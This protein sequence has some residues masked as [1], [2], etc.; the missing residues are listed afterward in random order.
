MADGSIKID[1]KIDSSSLPKQLRSMETEVKKST[2]AMGESF[3]K[4]RDVMQ[5]PVA[6]AKMVKD[7]L[8]AIGKAIIGPAA[9]IEDFVAA[10]TPLTGSV[11]DA[12]IM[13]SALNK[14]AATTP[15]ELT[16]IASVGKQLLPV[17]GNDVKKVTETFRML[18]DTAGGNAEKLD[19]IARGYVK[20]MNTGKVSME[21]LNMIS[22]AGVPIQSQLAKSMGITVEEM[23]KLSS[24]GNISASE[25]TKAFQTMTTE[26]GI[27][28]NGMAVASETLSGKTS[29]MNDSLKMAAAALGDRML[30]AVKDI[31]TAVSEA[32]NGFTDF[33]SDHTDLAKETNTLI[34]ASE[35][36]ETAVRNLDNAQ[37]DISDTERTLLTGRKELARLELQKALSETSKGY[38]KTK[39]EISDLKDVEAGHLRNLEKQSV[40]MKQLDIVANGPPAAASAA[41]KALG[42]SIEAAQQSYGKAAKNFE[43][44]NSKLLKVQTKLQETTVEYSESIAAL[45]RAVNDG[46]L[47]IDIY[48]L[49]NKELYNEVMAA[50]ES[51]KV[52]ARETTKTGAAARTAT[53]ATED[54]TDAHEDLNKELKKTPSILDDIQRGFEKAFGDF[55]TEIEED[56]ADWSDTFKS[57]GTSIT[58]GIGSSFKEVGNIIVNG[59]GFEEF[60]TIALKTL[61]EVLT[62]L[63]AQLAAIAV[64]KA[65]AYSYGE[66][67]AAGAAS[68][69]AFVASGIAGAMANVAT[70]AQQAAI[71]TSEVADKLKEVLRGG[72]SSYEDYLGTKQVK[73]FNG[74]LE[75]L[76][77]KENQQKEMLNNLGAAYND[78]SAEV[79]SAIFT[80]GIA[81]SQRKSQLKSQIDSQNAALKV[82]QNEIAAMQEVY[83]TVYKNNAVTSKSSEIL[84]NWAKDLNV[85]IL[86]YGKTSTE[87]KAVNEDYQD[88]LNKALYPMAAALKETNGTLKENKSLWTDAAKAT[89]AFQTSLSSIREKAASFYESFANIGSDIADTLV[90]SLVNGLDQQ[91]FMTSIKEFIMKAVIQ[92]AVYT[93]SMSKTLAAIGAK[94]ANAISSGLTGDA[95]SDAM[96]KIKEQ[97]AGVWNDAEKTAAAAKEVLTGVFG[98]GEKKDDIEKEREAALAAAGSSGKTQSEIDAINKIYNDRITA[99]TGYNAGLNSIAGGLGSSL[100]PS[101]STTGGANI[102]VTVN[103]VNNTLL[104]GRQ[105][106][107][108]FAENIDAIVAAI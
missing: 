91:D 25:L 19:S 36:Y 81:N 30:P 12:K 59:G 37:K 80:M 10:F 45:G 24:Q 1:T 34:T 43:N 35:K 42:I 48:K 6:V 100:T 90:D 46:T 66:A 14:E 54:E 57:I 26:G 69:A 75:K 47:K 99:S 96:K 76:K 13:I 77:A 106:A 4:M 101:L 31:T 93:E 23:Y 89:Y 11:K 62:A 5:G 53:T 63:G 8:V 27:F 52:L 71:S 38:A 61:S 50:A 67:M 88:L 73:D 79:M 87:V 103:A 29:T 94:I 32:A 18:G 44:E 58:D 68:A 85:A 95:L 105:I 49:T 20:V 56:A 102:T 9:E 28:Y 92:A 41:A 15:Y 60:G 82:T 16:T 22:D 3:A 17:L 83:D 108:S 74:E 104:D 7:G 86:A 40:L 72:R 84:E 70:E 39:K 98:T 78:M 2:S 97:L 107:T 33:I 51:Q 55:A 65:M 64:T 21:A